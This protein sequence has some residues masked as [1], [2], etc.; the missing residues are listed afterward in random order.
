MDRTELPPMNRALVTS[1][2]GTKDGRGAADHDEAY[3]FGRRPSAAAPF[4]FSDWQFARLLALRG[5]L[6]DTVVDRTGLT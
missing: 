6:M 5:R 2:A 1:R 3:V 4:P